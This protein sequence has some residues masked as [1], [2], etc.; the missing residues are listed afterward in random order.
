MKNKYDIKTFK[1]NFKLNKETG[2]LI[3]KAEDLEIGYNGCKIAKINLELYKGK[4]LGIIGGNG[5]GKSTLIKEIV[6][7]KNTAIKTSG[8]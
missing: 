5:T 3:L 8:Q 2:N 7:N 6:K 4:K 1:T